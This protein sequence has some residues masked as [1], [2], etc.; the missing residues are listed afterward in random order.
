MHDH[1][2]IFQMK[3]KEK[4]RKMKEAKA[5]GEEVNEPHCEKTGFRVPYLV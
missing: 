5:A 1:T 4:K 2:C 3:L